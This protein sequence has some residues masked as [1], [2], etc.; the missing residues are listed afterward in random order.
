MKFSVKDF[1]RKCEQIRFFL[2]GFAYWGDGESPPPLAKNLLI[3]PT[4]K[5]PSS[6]ILPHQNFIPS[7]KG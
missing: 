6:R 5:N 2:E 1:F 4:W 3:L 7:T